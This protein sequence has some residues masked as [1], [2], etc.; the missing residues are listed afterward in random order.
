MSPRPTSIWPVVS[1]SALL[2]AACGCNSAT[3]SSGSASP[4]QSPDKVAASFVRA[5]AAGKASAC[6]LMSATAIDEFEEISGASSCSDAVGL[7]LKQL[8]KDLRAAGPRALLAHLQD[9]KVERH[10]DHS[11]VK[12]STGE[13]AQEALSLVASGDSWRVD[14]V[15]F[16]RP[17]ICHGHPINSANCTSS[18]G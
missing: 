10:G 8:P 7:L 15:V 17:E 2:L 9:P 18:R 6:R 3:Q 1:A 16:S 11:S 13:G 5:L 14:S 12:F 4:A